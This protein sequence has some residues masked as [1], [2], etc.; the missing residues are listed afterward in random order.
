MPNEILLAKEIFNL[1]ISAGVPKSDINFWAGLK[2]LDFQ[3]CQ[4]LLQYCKT[5]STEEVRNFNLLLKE[6]ISVFKSGNKNLLRDLMLK[7][8][9][10]ILQ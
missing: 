2:G 1:I 6:K 3:T 10:F 4:A 7:E 9:D 8:R 5:A